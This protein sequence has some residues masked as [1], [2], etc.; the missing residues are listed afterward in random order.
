EELA[1]KQNSKKRKLKRKDFNEAMAKAQIPEK[2]IENLWKKKK[3]GMQNWTELIINSFIGSK[4]REILLELIEYR[5][6]QIDLN[7]ILN[8]NNKNER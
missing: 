4:Q 1:L 2:A 6:K 8:N 3:K 5:A 7:F